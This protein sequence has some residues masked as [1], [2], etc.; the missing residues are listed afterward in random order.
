MD[1]NNNN[2]KDNISDYLYVIMLGIVVFVVLGWLL[3][4]M[5]HASEGIREW[6]IKIMVNVV[7]IILLIGAPIWAVISHDCDHKK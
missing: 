6:A 7:L 2:D 3:L 5:A 4:G 1:R